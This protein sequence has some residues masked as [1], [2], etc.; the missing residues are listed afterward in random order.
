MLQK[1]LKKSK[2]FTFFTVKSLRDQ[3]HPCRQICQGQHK[4]KMSKTYDGPESLM[5]HT[6]FH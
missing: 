1:F 2:V 6:K 4:P 3:N 5:L